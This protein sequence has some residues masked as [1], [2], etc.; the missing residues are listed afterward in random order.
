[1]VMIDVRSRH[2][3]TEGVSPENIFSR[4]SP[5]TG[6]HTHQ[7]MH[8]FYYH[9]V[10]HWNISLP[11]NMK[12][13]PIRPSPKCPIFTGAA[14]GEEDESHNMLIWKI[15]APLLEGGLKVWVKSKLVHYWHA[16]YVTSS[17]ISD[18]A[19][20]VLLRLIGTKTHTWRNARTT[21]SIS[22][23]LSNFDS[24]THTHNSISV[25]ILCFSF[26]GTFV[27]G[28]MGNTSGIYIYICWCITHKTPRMKALDSSL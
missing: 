26:S 21:G 20:A 17:I 13:V 8:I 5:C 24:H 9:Q 1:M 11:G 18:T 16:V 28:F 25:L 3:N 10:I 23:S 12:K 6:R 7:H 14:T 19:V 2:A 15:G 4:T 22:T 27:W